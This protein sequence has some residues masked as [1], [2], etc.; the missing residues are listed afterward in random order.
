MKL[1]KHT[2]ALILA[3]ILSVSLVGCGAEEG[4]KDNLLNG[5]NDMLHTFS[6][7]AIT[8]DK[9][10]QG[11]RIFSEDSYTGSYQAVYDSFYGREVLFGGTG[12]KRERGNCLEVSYS[13]GITAGA[14]GLYWVEQ[15]EKHPIAEEGDEG[16]VL[17]NLS[18][19][20]NYIIVEGEEF[21]GT[22]QIEIRT[23]DSQ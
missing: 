19:G 14:G 11:T 5:F 17:I 18:S 15:G 20:D 7:K 1:L 9:E 8:V 2:A 13:L 6:Q 23:T 12:L 3:G 22:L 4:L 21:T 16:A 10:L